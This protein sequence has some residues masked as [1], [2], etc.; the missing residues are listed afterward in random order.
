MKVYRRAEVLE[1]F[2]FV[3][4]GLDDR[5]ATR[6]EKPERDEA[7][8]GEQCG[9]PERLVLKVVYTVL[10]RERLKWTF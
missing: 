7:Q 5:E 1:S 2:T 3:L 8:L 4:G 10:R 9:S 6:L